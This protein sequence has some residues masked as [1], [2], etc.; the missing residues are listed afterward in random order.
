MPTRPLLTRTPAEPSKSIFAA[1]QDSFAGALADLRRAVDETI[2]VVVLL[3]A[4]VVVFEA[5]A[6]FREE[7]AF[8]S[9]V[10]DAVRVVVPIRTTVA[11]EE[12]V[13]VLGV[14]SAV[15]VWNA[16]VN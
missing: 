8:V 6:I 14:V 10:I 4:T 16:N 9:L 11:V 5:V 1:P 7:G 3:G 15:V 2:L 12:V 13:E